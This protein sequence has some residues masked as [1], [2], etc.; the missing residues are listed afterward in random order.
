MANLTSEQTNRLKVR[1]FL[2]LNLI[3]NFRDNYTYL[4][5]GRCKI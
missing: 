5:K 4:L 1:Y 2:L 3:N